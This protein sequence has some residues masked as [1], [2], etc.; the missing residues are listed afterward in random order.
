MSNQLAPIS[1]EAPRNQA[2]IPELPNRARGQGGRSLNHKLE[3]WRRR[4]LNDGPIDVSV[5]IANWNCCEML[6]ACLESL[7]DQPQGVR[8]ETIV[9]DNA[10]TDGAGDMVEREFPE[11]I[12]HKN[13]T[14][15]GFARANNLAA[16][17]ARGRYLFFLNN[18]TVVPPGALARLVEYAKLHP[19]AGIIGPKLRD[20]QGQAQVSYRLRPDA[21]TLLHRTSL[22]RWTGLFRRAYR[23]YRRQDFDPETTRPV[24]VLMGAAMLLP[25][26]VFFAYGGWDEDFVFGGEDLDLSVRVG[27]H[28]LVVYH[29]AVEI[30]H[31]GRVSTRQHIGYASSNMAIGFLRYLRKR[32]H[33]QPALFLYKAVMTLDAP[34]QFVSKAL[35]FL[36]RRARG[37]RA[38][39]AKTL[40]AL[41]ASGH[42]LIKGLVPFWKA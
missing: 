33:S 20:G 21:A 8:L 38:K 1:L 27:Q 2:A 36:W 31:Y 6:R 39:A 12:L 34:V 11:V 26:E 10:S 42:F 32:G 22:L 5:C 18:D 15:L 13:P 29:P 41:R 23:R 37:R 3:A 16:Q 28:H 40:L 14:N 19:E 7:Q 25:R 30:T 17:Q 35:E 9:V 24:E 4:F